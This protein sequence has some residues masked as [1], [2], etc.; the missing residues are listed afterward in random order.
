MFILGTSPLGAQNATY[1]DKIDRKIE[2]TKKKRG[3]G[4]FSCGNA[5]SCRTAEGLQQFFLHR[6][7]I[8]FSWFSRTLWP[9]LIQ[10][11][12]CPFPENNC[13]KYK[14]FTFFYVFI[15]FKKV[16]LHHKIIIIVEFRKL[17]N[18]NKI[19]NHIGI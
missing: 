16:S 4:Q 7:Q 2:G 19:W 11:M 17:Q 14:L 3:M 15:G 10:K 18:K 1:I 9:R 5:T 6:I 12:H 8:L 13:R